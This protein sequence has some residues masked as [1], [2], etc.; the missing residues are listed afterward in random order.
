[1]LKAN[2]ND[3][4]LDYTQEQINQLDMIYDAIG[5]QYHI[6]KDGKSHKAQLSYN[7]NNPKE[8]TILLN[9]TEH[10]VTIKDTV[11]QMVDKMGLS[12]VED[13]TAGD[14]LAPMPGLI[15]D[16]MV[17]AG[18]PIYKGDSLLILEAMK[19]ENVIKAEADGIVKSV[20]LAK[21]DSVEKNQL[22]IEIEAD[23]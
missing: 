2:I 3:Q 8:I 7:N 22:I 23:A 12:V 16:I 20:C 1:M 9:G 6:L 10:T 17:S 5:N 4:S 18:D 14:I 11:D 21:G 13:A 19:M 15:L